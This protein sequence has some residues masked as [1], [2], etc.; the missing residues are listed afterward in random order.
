MAIGRRCGSGRWRGRSPARYDYRAVAALAA[1]PSSSTAEQRTFNPLVLGSNPRG[2]TAKITHSCGQNQDG[3]QYCRPCRCHVYPKTSRWR[4]E[5]RVQSVGCLSLQRW[6]QVRARVQGVHRPVLRC[7]ELED[8]IRSRSGQTWLAPEVLRLRATC[9]TSGQ[10]SDGRE[11]GTSRGR[12]KRMLLQPTCVNSS[13]DCAREEVLRCDRWPQLR[14][15]MPSRDRVLLQVDR[16]WSAALERTQAR[17]VVQA[18]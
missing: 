5:N 17:P 13:S 1:R 8:L 2:V 11:L 18:N 4:G 9:S 10:D 16:N 12:G 14:V 7:C 15:G 6:V 3:Q